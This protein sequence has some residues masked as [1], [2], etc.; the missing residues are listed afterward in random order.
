MKDK[1]GFRFR[2]WRIYIESRSFRTKIYDISK[3]FP[4]RENFGLTDQIRRAANSIILN[5]AEGANKR[6]DKDTRLYINRASCSLDE[7]VA[8]L[9]C[10]VDSGYITQTMQDKTLNEAS[11]LA[12]QLNAFAFRLSSGQSPAGAGRLIA[13]SQ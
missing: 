13:N 10:A 7:V 2:D 8:C 3:R 12:K 5:I 6:S 4:S 1:F 11:V 9:D